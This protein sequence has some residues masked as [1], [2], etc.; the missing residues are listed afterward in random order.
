L[1]K[2]I[3][4]DYQDIFYMSIALEAQEYWRSDPIYKAFY[5]ESGMLYA[6]DKGMAR[7]SLDNL[8]AVGEKYHAGIWNPEETRAR[9]DGIFKDA[10]WDGV[11]ETYFKPQSGW[12]EADRVLQSVIEAGV[13][14]SFPMLLVS[15]S[16]LSMI[17]PIVL[18]YR[19][20]MMVS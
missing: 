8:N 17:A 3:R 4:A 13:K 11:T 15:R 10:K 1:N 6:E 16:F 7:A 12:G 2:I 9:V 5:H 20:K 19:Q 14:V 18:G